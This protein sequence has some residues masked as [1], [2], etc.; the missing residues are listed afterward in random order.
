MHRDSISENSLLYEFKIAFF[1]NGKSEKLF[2]FV[3]NFDMTLKVSGT[4]KSG[5]NIQYIRTLV[6]KE[7]LHQ[8]D[9]LSDE[10]YGDSPETLTCIILGLGA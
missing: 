8:F 6:R 2:L 7:A 3:C 1:D 4:L 10:V 9:E 5:A